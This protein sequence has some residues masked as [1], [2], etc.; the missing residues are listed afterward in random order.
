MPQHH[1]FPSQCF[2]TSFL[3]SFHWFLQNTYKKLI[4]NRDRDLRVTRSMGLSGQQV[5]CN[6]NLALPKLELH[7]ETNNH[8]SRKEGEKMCPY[9]FWYRFGIYYALRPVALPP[10]KR[11]AAYF[12]WF[13]CNTYTHVHVLQYTC[14][15]SVSCSAQREFITLAYQ[16]RNIEF[17]LYIFV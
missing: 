17:Y 16:Q 1:L 13:C 14:A 5:C 4:M 12:S 10:E 9:F 3:F 11:Q 8:L 15:D 7:T 2:F 6:P